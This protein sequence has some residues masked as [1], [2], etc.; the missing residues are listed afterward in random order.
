[1]KRIDAR[2]GSLSNDIERLRS[3]AETLSESVSV[4][5]RLKDD[6]TQ[7]KN[8]DQIV[9][10]SVK[11][12]ET[13]SGSLS[14]DIR[15]LRYHAETLSESVSSLQNLVQRSK[16]DFPMEVPNSTDGIIAYLTKKHG[17][18]VHSRGIVTITSKSVGGAGTAPG[19]VADLT[20]E[21]LFRSKDEPG[22]WICWDFGEMRVRPTHYTLRA[23]GM[24]SWITEASADNKNWQPID[25]QT[26]STY[27]KSLSTVSFPISNATEC[28]FLRLTEHSDDRPTM[29]LRVVEFFGTLWE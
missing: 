13:R 27:F 19:N 22:Q 12:I 24:R 20:S 26:N 5:P 25:R 9:E 1:V 29:A 21:S 15:R 6:L 3:Q 28:R 11:R 2:T 8:R 14:D 16:V 23:W 18:N 7:L 4:V 17:G 10:A